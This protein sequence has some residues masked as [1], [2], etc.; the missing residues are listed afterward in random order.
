MYLKAFPVTSYFSQL[1]APS[2][3]QHLRMERHKIFHAKRLVDTTTCVPTG[4]S[5]LDTLYVWRPALLA[6][7]SNHGSYLYKYKVN[8]LACQ[9]HPPNMV[10]WREHK[11]VII[12]TIR[13]Y[14]MKYPPSGFQH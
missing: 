7:A 8:L 14:S 6:A 1:Y 3:G 11:F 13:D 2:H 10:Q 4:Y 5:T 12:Y 9:G